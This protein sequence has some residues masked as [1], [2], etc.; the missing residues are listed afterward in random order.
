MNII[1]K[2]KKTFIS[3]VI[4]SLVISILPAVGILGFGYISGSQI[5]GVSETMID[6]NEQ[7]TKEGILIE[8]YF[9]EGVKLEVKYHLYRENGTVTFEML[10]ESGERISFEEGD[11]SY[12]V[13]IEEAGNYTVNY[14][15]SDFTGN[16]IL[17]TTYES[18]F[19]N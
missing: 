18:S 11:D 10:N 2:Y 1:L 19:F 8:D 6:F 9:D 13:T 4:I 14:S 15:V 12:Y 17:N 16:I 5:V 7:T 3:V